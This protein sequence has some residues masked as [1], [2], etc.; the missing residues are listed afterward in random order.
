MRC[1]NSAADRAAEYD[2]RD[3]TCVKAFVALLAELAGS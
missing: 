2:P 3:D 1:R